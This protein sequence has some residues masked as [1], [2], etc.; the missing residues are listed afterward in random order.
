MGQSCQRP[1]SMHPHNL[2]GVLIAGENSENRLFRRGSLFN[3]FLGCILVALWK[4]RGVLPKTQEE[5]HR[6]SDRNRVGTAQGLL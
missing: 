6:C 2:A 3:T 4:R 5:L 1:S